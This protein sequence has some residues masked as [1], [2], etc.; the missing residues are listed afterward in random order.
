[1]E[2]AKDM[3][4][5]LKNGQEEKVDN[6]WRNAK[7]KFALKGM[8]SKIGNHKIIASVLA[9]KYAFSN[10]DSLGTILIPLPPPPEEA[11]IIIGYPIFLL[12]F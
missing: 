1:M 9:V 6:E 3:V 8:L 11:F 12:L 4:L 5:D 7:K 10:S 2:Y